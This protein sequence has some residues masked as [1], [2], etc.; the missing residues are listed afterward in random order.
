MSDIM[1]MQSQLTDMRDLIEFLTSNEDYAPG[2]IVE[3][4][5][6][7]AN[8]ILTDDFKEISHYIARYT[9]HTPDQVTEMVTDFQT[10]WR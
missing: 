2:Y 4:A 3:M 1:R 5:R 9:R 10:N 6:V 8:D 7:M